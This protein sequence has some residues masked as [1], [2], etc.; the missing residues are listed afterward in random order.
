MYDVEQVTMGTGLKINNSR[1]PTPLVAFVELSSRTP[2]HFW[3]AT[4]WLVDERR[5]LTLN[6]AYLRSF[7]WHV[8]ITESRFDLVFFYGLGIRIVW[9]KCVIVAAVL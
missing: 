2:R 8:N 1:V 7:G 9:K 3:I 4:M 5:R 6:Y